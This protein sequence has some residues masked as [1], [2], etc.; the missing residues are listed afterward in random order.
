MFDKN[1]KLW[2]LLR[3]DITADDIT[4][5]AYMD[6][7]F[8]V[9]EDKDFWDAEA[10]S[11]KKIL[12]HL[13]QHNVLLDF[14]NEKEVGYPPEVCNLGSYFNGVG[15][16]RVAC[17][18]CFL[19]IE[20]FDYLDFSGMYELFDDSIVARLILA[21]FLLG[22]E[23]KQALKEYISDQIDNFKPLYTV[24]FIDE[25]DLLFCAY[26]Y[27]YLY[28][29]AREFNDKELALSAI[30]KST[31]F[32]M[33][34]SYLEV[35]YYGDVDIFNPEWLSDDVS[36]KSL[37][38]EFDQQCAELFNVLPRFENNRLTI[39]AGSKLK[40]LAEKSNPTF[41]PKG[42]HSNKDKKIHLKD[43]KW[44]NDIIDIEEL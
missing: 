33:I 26:M 31:K 36:L 24:D 19:S 1:Y 23:Y 35:F 14:P 3:R 4:K 44:L 6:W 22:D 10:L 9:D 15:S 21:S 32:F 16:P 25:Y 20:I 5:I 29:I 37:S 12:M 40:Y 27:L 11:N 28:I 30:L 34:Y 38:Q 7:G 2:K 42:S 43:L 41:F 8:G 39:K 18:C 17:F 13:V